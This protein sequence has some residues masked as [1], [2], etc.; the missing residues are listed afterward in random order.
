MQPASLNFQLNTIQVSIED[1]FLANY[2]K[3]KSVPLF[4]ALFLVSL[5]GSVLTGF[6]FSA[7]L[8]TGGYILFCL[9]GITFIF[10][11]TTSGSIVDLCEFIILKSL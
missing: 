4:I 9:Y 6:M 10:M 5:V 1:A 2:T 3:I 7:K 11:A 8:D